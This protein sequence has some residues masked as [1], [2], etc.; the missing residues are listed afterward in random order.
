MRVTSDQENDPPLRAAFHR[1]HAAGKI[2]SYSIRY[3]SDNKADFT[4]DNLSDAK[5][6]HQ[7]LSTEVTGIDVSDPTCTNT[8]MVHIVGLTE[9]DTTTSVYNA[10]S[11]PGRN[12]AIEHLIN[13]LEKHLPPQKYS[14]RG[15]EIRE[16]HSESEMPA[17][18]KRA[19]SVI[20][21]TRQPMQF[22]LRSSNRKDQKD[23]RVPLNKQ[24]SVMMTSC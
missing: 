12:R 7:C 4:F 5:S 21:I 14:K 6:A 20:S 16:E 3:H 17:Q 13:P 24:H 18:L 1:A 11:K 23:A 19:D 10:L 2:G 15:E 22:V 8:K 9:D